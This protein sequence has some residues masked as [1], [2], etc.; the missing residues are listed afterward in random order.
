MR[1]KTVNWI[2]CPRSAHRRNVSLKFVFTRACAGSLT[3]AR[4]TKK[5]L[6]RCP[7]REREPVYEISRVVVSRSHVGCSLTK[8]RNHESRRVL[9][10]AGRYSSPSCKVNGQRAKCFISPLCVEIFILPSLLL[11]APSLCDHDGC[12][13]ALLSA[14]ARRF[15]L[16]RDSISLIQRAETGRVLIVSFTVLPV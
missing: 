11:F 16:K 15:S 12:L 14:A 10:G 4:A 13:S 1:E 6:W 8:H 3:R 5:E 7:E 9:R 2:R